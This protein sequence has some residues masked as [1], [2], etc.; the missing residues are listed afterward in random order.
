MSGPLRGCH[1]DSLHFHFW[2]VTLK[3]CSLHCCSTSY[4]SSVGW[5]LFPPSD[6]HSDWET[7]G[8]LGLIWS[9]G[10]Y[11]VK[12][13]EDFL[14]KLVKTEEKVSPPAET[15]LRLLVVSLAIISDYPEH[16]RRCVHSHVSGV[17][18]ARPGSSTVNLGSSFLCVVIH[19][20]VV[21]CHNTS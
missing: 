15:Y 17:F 8:S 10:Y 13:R 1:S 16:D 5:V 7:P 4:C 21:L 11:C 2:S 14:W 6:L 3:L 19:L 12:T 20:V 9:K 18:G